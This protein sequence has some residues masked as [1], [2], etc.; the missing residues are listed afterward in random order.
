MGL[1]QVPGTVRNPADR[2]KVW[3]GRFLVDTGAV[4]SLVPRRHLETIGIE[5]ER[6]RVYGLANGDNVSFDIGFAL[7]EFM[8]EV[9][10]STVVFG[11]ENSEPLLGV[12]ALESAGVEVN[13]H[14]EKLTKL[15]FTRLR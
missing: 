13:P 2:D 3:E 10:A 15:P 14:D 9:V 12:T 1:I 7:I 4:D 5:P 6:Q 8:G 11:D